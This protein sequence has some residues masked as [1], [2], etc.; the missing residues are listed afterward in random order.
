LDWYFLLLFWQAYTLLFSR[1]SFPIALL[2]G[3]ARIKGSNLL[4]RSLLTIQFALSVVVLIA[5]ISF[6]QNTEYQEEINLGYNRDKVL[7]V[8]V[9]GQNDFAILKNEVKNNPKVEMVGV[10]KNSFGWGSY[11]IAVGIDTAEYK[12]VHY[13]IGEN[14]HEV[15]GVNVI[16]G[17]TL[18]LNNMTDVEGSIV[19]NQ[20]FVDKVNMEDPINKIIKVHEVKRKIVGVVDNHIGNLFSSRQEEAC[21]FYPAKKDEYSVML[22]KANSEDLLEIKESTET[23]WK[24]HFPERTYDARLQSEIVLK[25]VR[26][27]NTNLKKIFIFLTILG[28]LL[29]ENTPNIIKPSITTVQSIGTMK[30]LPPNKQNTSMILS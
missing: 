18:N 4:T 5:G 14:Y 3:N 23:I 12:A 27:T 30:L 22:I 2:K 17:R 20:A 7:L 21:L 8:S 28:G 16:E 1:V 19:V 13:S 29:S 24:E 11:S 9:Q 15:M 10:T 6:V 26:D 25:G